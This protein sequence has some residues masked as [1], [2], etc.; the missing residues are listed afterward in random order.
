MAEVLRDVMA[1]HGVSSS[2]RET[3]NIG[4]DR[5]SDKA[6]HHTTL[7]A[8]ATKLSEPQVLPALLFVNVSAE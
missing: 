1:C 7:A 4:N 5:P 6:E 8:S 2:N 3:R